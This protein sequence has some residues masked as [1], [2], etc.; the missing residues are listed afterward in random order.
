[1]DK[2]YSSKHY[3]KQPGCQK[4]NNQYTFATLKCSTTL[5]TRLLGKRQQYMAL[6]TNKDV[7]N[8]ADI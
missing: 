5:N 2:R 1:M 7:K 8:V 6:I 4:A 3:I